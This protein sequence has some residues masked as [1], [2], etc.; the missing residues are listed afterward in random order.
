MKRINFSIKQYETRTFL[1]DGG[2]K[3]NRET[4]RNIFIHNLK[5]QPAVSDMRYV[6]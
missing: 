3:M 4:K 1:I 6:T 2:I 5:K